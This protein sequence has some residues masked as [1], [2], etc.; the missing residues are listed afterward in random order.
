[1]KEKVPTLYWFKPL[2]FSEGFR[3]VACMIPMLIALYL[4]YDSRLSSLGQGGFYYAYLPL[5]KKAGGRIVFT[6]LLLTIGLGFYLIGGNV[7]PY[8]WLAILF[9]FGVGAILV[10]L[11]GWK[12]IGVLAFSF[13]SFYAAGLNSSSPEKASASFMAF[14]IAIL[15]AG[16]I[17]L[18]PIWKGAKRW[19]NRI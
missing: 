4:G 16:S 5:P 15:W 9:T 8:K 2:M 6:F 11:S 18:L 7:V 12:I 19:L 17:S 1:M 13:I 10:L 14:V 3:A